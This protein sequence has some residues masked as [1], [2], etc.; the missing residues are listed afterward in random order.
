MNGIHIMEDTVGTDRSRTPGIYEVSLREYILAALLMLAFF[1][2][3]SETVYIVVLFWALFVLHGVF[4]TVF[5][6]RPPRSL[7]KGNGN[8]ET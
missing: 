1:S 3:F 4:C 2:S 6:L 8:N 7:P 5:G